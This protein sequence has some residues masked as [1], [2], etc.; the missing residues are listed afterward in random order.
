MS[1]TTN[2][3]IINQSFTTVEIK[4]V[5]KMSKNNK[6][7]STDYMIND[8]FKH[9]HI[10][11]ITSIVIFFNIVLCTGLVPTEWCLGIINPIYKNKG[12][13]SDQDNYR[14]IT[15][16]SCTCKLFTACINTRL[17][18]YVQQDILGEEQAGFRHGYITIDHIYVLQ[19]IIEL[20]QSVYKR[21]YCAFIDYRKAF[22]SLDR[23]YLWQKLLS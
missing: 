20:Y 9:C 8:L 22:D 13:R 14:G 23:N 21:V 3:D 1:Q 18:D 15:L 17:S 10:D 6:S 19:T 5:N 7:P 2:N 11:C 16:L 4:S 12:P